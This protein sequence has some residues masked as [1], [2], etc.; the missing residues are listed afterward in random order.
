MV[1]HYCLTLNYLPLS[2]PGR[3]NKFKSRGNNPP[4]S[5]GISQLIGI[6]IGTK[7][8][9]FINADDVPVAD[10]LPAYVALFITRQAYVVTANGAF[11]Y[12]AC[13][14]ITNRTSI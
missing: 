13:W 11:Q 7:M 12:P 10:P 1:K 3:Q 6:T 2:S 4:A 14:M 8:N 5:V 9:L